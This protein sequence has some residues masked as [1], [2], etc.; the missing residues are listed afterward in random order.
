MLTAGNGT[1]RN[2]ASSPDRKFFVDTYSRVDVP[3][4]HELRRSEDGLLVCTLERA[5]ISALLATGWKAPERFVA[6]GPR[7]R[8]RTSTGSSGGRPISIPRASIPS[9]KIS[10][11]VRTARLCRSNSRPI[12][13]KCRLPS[14]DSSWSRSTAWAPRIA[15]RRFTTCAGRTWAIVRFPGRIPWIKAGGRKVPVHGY[16]TASE[17]TAGRPAGRARPRA[18]LAHGDFY[19]VAVSDCGCHDN[20]MDKIWWNEL[21]MGW[22]L[23]DHYEQQSNVTQAHRLQ[24]KLLLIVGELDRNVD[25]A[26]TMQVVNALI[27]ADKDFDMLVVPGGGHGIAESTYGTRRRRDFFRAALVGSGASPTNDGQPGRK[28]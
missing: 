10:M 28:G 2:P 13:N 12:P 9:S 11:P 22:P 21:W 4:V 18:L 20:R 23:G 7:W 25:P 6:K 3:P 27:K 5:D 24:G 26:S 15:P 17:S 14:W 8:R 1:H 19:H 16:V